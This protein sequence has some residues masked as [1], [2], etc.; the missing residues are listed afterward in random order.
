MKHKSEIWRVTA[1][2]ANYNE[3]G[4]AE[5]MR[6]TEEQMK[7]ARKV[8]GEFPPKGQEGLWL[9]RLIA[10]LEAAGAKSIEIRD[11]IFCAPD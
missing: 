8:V 10:A 11:I 5:V 7:E 4:R 2:D 6:F 1:V 3:V 9:D